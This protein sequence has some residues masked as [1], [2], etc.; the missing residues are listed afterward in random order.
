MKTLPLVLLLMF[1]LS[2]FAVV[3]TAENKAFTAKA[4]VVSKQVNEDLGGFGNLE[5]RLVK[6]FTPMTWDAGAGIAIQLLTLPEWMPVVE[7]RKVFADAL[8][9][10]QTEN[11]AYIGLAIS[12]KPA[13]QDD[14]FR[15]GVEVA[16]PEPWT[17]WYIGKAFNFG[18]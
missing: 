6:P 9:S 4:K 13:D 14:G 11:Q 5:G 18:W 8:V 7:S 3:A 15:L 10:T 17:T 1:V 2:C 16:G 12:L